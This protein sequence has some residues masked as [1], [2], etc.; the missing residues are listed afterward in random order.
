MIF[1]KT[2]INAIKCWADGK[3]Q[4]KVDV[5]KGKG[6][7]TEDYTTEEKEKLTS[8]ESGAEKNV[9]PNWNQ[10]NSDAAD[11]IQN[12]PFY[13]GEAVLTNVI[14]ETTITLQQ[15]GDVYG[16]TLNNSNASLK[17]GTTY[18]TNWNGIEYTSVGR[19]VQGA[20]CIGDHSIITG[21][22]PTGEPF[23]I[24]IVE[25]NC[26]IYAWDA[27]SAGETRT[28]SVSNYAKKIVKIP[29]KYL[30]I[31]NTNTA[32]MVKL[33]NPD[34]VDE[35]ARLGT[36]GINSQ[37]QL[38]PAIQRD[39]IFKGEISTYSN[40]SIS[41]WRTRYYSYHDLSEHMSSNKCI[42]SFSGI[43]DG[44]VQINSRG[45][46]FS[47]TGQK[48]IC[49]VLS[50]NGLKYIEPNLKIIT[51]EGA[52]IYLNRINEN[53][54]YYFSVDPS[55][56]NVQSFEMTLQ[57]PSFGW[58]Y[59]INDD[60]LSSN[61]A[62]IKDVDDKIAE[63]NNSITAHEDIR[64]LI[65]A[66]KDGIAFKDQ[67]ND[68]TYIVCMRD[69]NI[70]SYIAIKSIEVTTMPTK[71]E[72]T[73]GE[74]FDPTD[75]IITVTTYDGITKEITDYTYSSDY[76]TEDTTFIEVSYIEGGIKH[77]ASVPVTVNAFDAATILVDFEYTDNGD[78]TYT[79]TG[80]KGTYNG[81]A[82]TEMIVPNYGCII[83]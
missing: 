68:Y 11:Y 29:E 1:T 81:E 71:I 74:Y 43:T 30:N 4:S 49:D 55:S 8:I 65:T 15:T 5:V 50:D 57:S 78:G 40:I 6:L 23:F 3:L 14:P 48:I 26:I 46:G 67:I 20:Y 16:T 59:E 7:S 32:G 70:A 54:V 61:I 22:T 10:N 58:C 64:E 24:G 39:E 72:Y 21:G 53:G 66:P 37:G 56:T 17:V 73:V 33:S 41:Y 38:V 69:G 9:Q 76:L 45:R 82:S 2:I 19:N 35:E 34:E 28:F 60:S 47:R 13:T 63:H 31:A 77:I 27:T 44:Y 80:W 75:M 62:R 18:I 25:N 36:I 51:H 52:S 79:I 42:F 83:V 12:R